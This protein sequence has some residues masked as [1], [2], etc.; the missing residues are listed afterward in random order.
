[1]AL[2]AARRPPLCGPRA[3][4]GKFG[5]PGKNPPGVQVVHMLDCRNPNE[6]FVS[7]IT[8]WRVQKILLKPVPMK[9]SGGR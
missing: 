5:K 3:A 9:S 6:L 2:A 7:E 1:M 8:D 4:L